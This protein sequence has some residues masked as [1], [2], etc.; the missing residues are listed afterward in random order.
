MIIAATMGYT[1]LAL[2]R[3]FLMVAHPFPQTGQNDDITGDV[4][5]SHCGAPTVGRTDTPLSDN[6]TLLRA[7]LSNKELAAVPYPHETE[8]LT[9]VSITA[10][11]Q[12]SKHEHTPAE[13]VRSCPDDNCNKFS[14]SC[15]HADSFRPPASGETCAPQSSFAKEKDASPPKRAKHSKVYPY[16]I[17]SLFDGVGSA[18]PAITKAIGCAPRIIIVAECDPILRQLV[19]EQ[20]GLRTDGEWTQTSK[21]TYTLYANDVRQLIRNQCQ[22]LKEAFAL[23][24]PQCRW[25]VIAGSPC[26]DLTP[27]GPL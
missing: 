13:D 6:V 25:F 7:D 3:R 23:A 10:S 2:V 19:G 4:S 14:P 9:P 1:W 11:A 26:Q 27:A 18:I 20:F 15:A 22:I 5:E 17:I 21:D 12:C 24:G 8:A 16:A